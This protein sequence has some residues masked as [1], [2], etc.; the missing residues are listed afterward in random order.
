MAPRVMHA[1]QS[2]API[3]AVDWSAAEDCY[4]EFADAVQRYVQSIVHDAY[5]AED[6][7]HN[8]FIKLLGSLDSY[9]ESKAPFSAWILRIA[10]NAA[11]DHLRRRR[12]WP[13][14][15]LPA[16]RTAPIKTDPEAIATL[17]EAFESLPDQQRLVMFL[18]CVLG[19][20]PGEIAD[21]LDRTPASVNGLEHRGRGALKIALRRA[22]L[23]PA[24][25]ANGQR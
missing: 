10:R 6:I 11:L 19:L 1:G 8:V 4:V 9:D 17:R 21:A 24:T 5:E 16:V 2:S 13:S 25:V 20:S 14:D 23:Q 15:E 22:R 3:E 18:R 7:T 12:T